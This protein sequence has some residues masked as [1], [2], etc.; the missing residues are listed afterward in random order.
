MAHFGEMMVKL[1][2]GTNEDSFV[3]QPN[4]NL[5]LDK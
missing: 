2:K 3:A 4:Q 1:A 5:L